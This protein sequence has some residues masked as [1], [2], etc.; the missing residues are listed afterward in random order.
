MFVENLLY[1][2]HCVTS[3]NPLQTLYYTTFL[4]SNLIDKE[5]EVE[6]MWLPHCKLQRG[7][8]QALDGD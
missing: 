5:T 6:S 2:P 7:A 4:D 8:I 1:A 3:F